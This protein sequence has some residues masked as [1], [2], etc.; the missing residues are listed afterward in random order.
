[1]KFNAF[2]QGWL[3]MWLPQKLL[4]KIMKLVIVLLS[5]CLMQVSAA[6]F[7]QM[8]SLS[9]R[10]MSLNQA[11]ENISLQ[12]NVKV[13]YADITLNQAKNVN[14]VLNNVTLKQALDRIFAK[15]E[16][17]YELKENTIIIKL[18]KMTF[19]DQVRD[20]T[21]D[22]LNANIDV[23][24]RVLDSLGVAL[25][26]ATVSVRGSSKAVYTNANG[27]FYLPGLKGDETL[28]IRYTGYVTKVVPVN[29]DLR[30]IR[31]RPSNSKLDEVLV[32]GYGTT[33]KRLSTGSTSLV[34]GSEL[35]QQ[36]ISNPILGLQGRVT[37]AF[38]TQ[39][40]GYAGATMKVII[41]GQNSLQAQTNNITDPLY[42]I[43]GIPFGST[44]VEQSIG[45][46][47]VTFAFS[48]LNTID[49]TQI[50]SITVLKDAD[51]TAIYGSRGA[52]GVVLITTKKGKAGSTKIDFD[53]SSGIGKVSNKIKMLNTDQYLSMRREAFANDNIT[54]NATNA[55]DL[56]LWSPG[57]YTN[58]PDLLMDHTQHQT[59]A[60]FSVSG[61]DQYTQFLFG[62]NYRHESTVL[63][64]NTA[65]NAVQFH[66]SAQHSSR[67]NQFGISTSVSYNV[68]NNTVPNYT[69]NT[70]NYGLP[71]NYPLYN[72]DGSLYF[73]PGYT[74]PLAAFNSNYNVKS[75]NLVANV[76]LHY[77]VLPGLDF[78]VNAGYNYINTFAS[79]VQPPSSL[80]PANNFAPTTTMSN[81]FIKTY[82][83]EP[84]V[85]YTHTWGKGKLTAL[86]GGTWQ[87]TRLTQPYFILGN[88]TNIQLATSLTALTILAKSSNSSDYKY[89]SG[90]ARV[91]YEW[92]GKYLVSGNF[93]RDGSSRFGAN[94]PYG[95]FGSGAV[96]WIF[97]KENFIA[98]SMPW[99]S[100]GKLKASYGVVGNDKT[101]ADY[102]YLSTYNAGTGYGPYSSLAPARIQNPYLQWEVNKKFDAAAELG[103]L[104]D[105]IFLSAG[106]YRNRAN[107]LLANI[108]IP[109]QAGFNSYSGNLPN[110]AVVQNQGFEFELSTVN[111]KN[112]AFSWNSSF[113]FTAS[114]NKLLSFP[115]IGS[116]NYASTLVVGQ[117]LNLRA[118]YHSTGIVN[119][120][121]TAQDVNRDGNVTS[122]LYANNGAGDRIVSGH[123]DPEYYGG[124]SN[125]FS[126]KGFQLDFLFQFVKRT[127]TR[128]DQNFVSYPGLNANLPE[129]Y[130]D[131]PLK[132]SATFGTAALNAFQFY[133]GSDAAVEDASY[134]RLKNVSLAYKVPTAWAKKLKMSG[135]QFYVQGQNLLTITDYK[136]LDPETLTN[137][138]PPLRMIVAGIKTTF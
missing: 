126:Y 25:Q 9:A 117:S 23:R 36:P 41:R 81:N 3:L 102:A 60:T 21:Q 116:S 87:E 59:K 15:Q 101:L 90:F 57:A 106:V 66:T 93:R 136:G 79:T 16:L 119:G 78:R 131:V 132:Y 1:M 91:E 88:F 125:T 12:S 17:D 61:G 107:H 11:L 45:G 100:F 95:T 27:E 52:N 83:A 84:Q 18:K 122:G 76:N 24:G 31:L 54:P 133:Q 2:Y 135:L 38:I 19:L 138:V 30:G 35:N 67:D 85:N 53:I 26:G 68:D 34:K 73:G 65:D 77:M 49:P 120:I 113:N 50:E 92:D 129:S 14:I 51:A 137:Q 39:T 43:D 44:P 13:V 62:G 98:N 111:F 5:T 105:R 121:P 118:V 123:N 86:L 42:I 56:T 74:N 48:P 104:H 20:L 28:E 64:S 82:I 8:I 108:A 71:P 94:N 6:T 69:L 127:A 115:N 40:A 33:T 96:A 130:L 128:G 114:R 89:D 112:K 109:S 58:F 10:N 32:I 110:G 4:L 7:G 103:F 63:K 70:T 75:N 37:G 124:L 47:G 55:P 72:S 22:L 134:I 80:N 99:L 97:S 46:F 29:S